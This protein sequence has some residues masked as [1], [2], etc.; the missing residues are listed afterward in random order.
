MTEIK[1]YKTPLKAIRIFLLSIP[2]VAIGIWEIIANDPFTFDWIMGLIC[3][4]FFSLGLV[5]GIFHFVDKRPQIIIN[6]IGIWDRTTKQDMIR[7]EQIKEAYPISIN[8]QKFLSIVTDNSYL[9]KTEQYKWA[10]K[11]SEKVGAQKL[12]FQVSQIKIDENRFAEFINSMILLEK[13]DR[14]KKLKEYLNRKF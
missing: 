6:E 13:S 10:T 12:N 5:V 14:E 2:L 3:A 8:R 11:L 4:S 7:W 9:F 1:L